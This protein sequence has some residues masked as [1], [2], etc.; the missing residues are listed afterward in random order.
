[1][2]TCRVE[3][4]DGKKAREYLNKVRNNRD[5]SQQHLNNLIERQRRHE[6]LTNGD[7]I[8]FDTTGDL[9]DGQHRMKMVSI[10]EIPIEVVVVEGIEPEAFTTMDV[11]RKRTLGDVLS[12]KEYQS[13]YAL[14]SALKW[15]RRYLLNNGGGGVSHEQHLVTLGKLPEL[16]SSVQFIQGIERPR[17]APN[18]TDIVTA[19]HF[20]CSLIKPELADDYITR[21]ITGE[22]IMNSKTDP[23]GRWRGQVVEYPHTVNPPTSLRIFGGFATVWNLIVDEKSTGQNIRLASK[24]TN[25]PQLKGFPK[26][27]LLEEQASFGV[28]FGVDGPD[29]AERAEPELARV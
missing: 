1:M 10:T 12:I 9:R 28:D 4:I 19:I 16:L 7:T 18:Y 27:R 14:S 11:G 15:A 24:P 23:V 25:R 5:E 17:A 29:D 26:D 13:P 20:L 21:F 3:T 2:I 8:R 6:W 22:R